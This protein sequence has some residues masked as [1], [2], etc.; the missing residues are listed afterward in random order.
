MGGM[1]ALGAG[2]AGAGGAGMG[3]S[4][5]GLGGGMG[6]PMQPQ[7][8]GPPPEVMQKI[9]SLL[10]SP[11]LPNLCPGVKRQSTAIGEACW[12][13]IWVHAG[14]VESTVPPYEQWHNTQTMEI[15][16]ADA[17][18]WATLPSERHRKTCYGSSGE[19]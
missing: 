1:G 18:Q 9:Q 13:K 11:D 8:Q 12:K 6:A 10:E 16:V 19:L 17:A 15:L 7:G 3:G 4:P 14:C 5:L 2:G